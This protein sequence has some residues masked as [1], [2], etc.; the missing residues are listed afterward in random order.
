MQLLVSV[1]RAGEAI[2]AVD[3]G[4]DIVDAKDPAAGALGAVT[5]GVFADIAAAVGGVKPLSAA[6]GE[7]EDDRQAAQ[8]T[9]A[10]GAAGARFVKLGFRPDAPVAAMTQV[11]AGARD[12]SDAGVI[13]AAYADVGGAFARQRVVDAAVA[14]GIAGVLLDTAHKAGPGLSDLCSPEELHEWATQVSAAGLLVA[15]AG[16]LS[17]E[18]IER[19]STCG[20]AIVGVRGAACD[21]GRRTGQV[22]RARVQELKAACG[23]T[24]GAPPAHHV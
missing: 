9:A 6:L 4:A 16:R 5:L 21:D 15:L 17:L 12:A 7:P 8:L 23:A 1:A 18:D 20:A 10:F 11:L 19:L 3:G 22:S 14:A 24:R 2:A 13:A